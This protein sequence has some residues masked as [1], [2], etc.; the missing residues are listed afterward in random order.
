M[1]RKWFNVEIETKFDK[2]S[3]ITVFNDIYRSL[4]NDQDIEDFYKYLTAL[5]YSFFN[6]APDCLRNVFSHKI[7]FHAKFYP[8]IVDGL[9][10]MDE[11]SNKVV[12]FGKESYEMRK[13]I[14][15]I[16]E[17][18]VG[19]VVKT[20]NVGVDDDDI[21]YVSLNLNDFAMSQ[22]ALK[23]IVDMKGKKVARNFIKFNFFASYNRNKTIKIAG[24]E[25]DGAYASKLSV[26][27]FYF[28]DL[29]FTEKPIKQSLEDNDPIVKI[30][31]EFA[32]FDIE[33]LK[34]NLHGVRS[35]ELAGIEDYNKHIKDVYIRMAFEFAPESDPKKSIEKYEVFSDFIINNYLPP[36]GG[37]PKCE[38]FKLILKSVKFDFMDVS[39]D[40]T[41]DAIS[42]A[43]H[44]FRDFILKFMSTINPSIEA[45]NI[46]KQN[47]DELPSKNMREYKVSPDPLASTDLLN[48]EM[49]SVK[50]FKCPEQSPQK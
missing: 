23:C 11:D 7:Q 20:C 24:Q 10:K 49:N 33:G 3:D 6:D 50:E 27:N 5:K 4:R 35:P 21:L 9:K 34:L 42:T 2:K 25:V 37:I 8:F 1:E 15:D 46:S 19:E 26:D 16:F 14:I 29:I 40:D 12:D 36:D 31:T 44:C 43:D 32:E 47:D 30:N 48:F 38:N 13:E 17:N 39:I 28:G 45:F 22:I 41:F 18:E